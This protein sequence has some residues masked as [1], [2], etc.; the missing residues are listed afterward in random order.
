MDKLDFLLVLQ[1]KLLHLPKDDVEERLNFYN[2][3]IEDQIEEGL[4][5]EEAVSSIDSV[6][7]I[8][9]QIK[10]EI[11][12]AYLDTKLTKV[13]RKRKPVETILLIIGSPIWLSL[14][15][16]TFAVVLSL[17]ISLW[18]VVISLWSIF[19][20]LIGCAFGTVVCSIGFCIDGNIPSGLVLIAASLI[21]A[22]LCIFLF[23]VCKIVTNFAID[24]VRKVFRLRKNTIQNKEE[25]L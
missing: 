19:A 17:Y 9:E 25:A 13:K 18:A 14:L 7:E 6:D 11:D 20:S 10:T 23:F 21:C 12:S 3:M 8:A 1:E 24:L 2:E 22:G 5:E 15:I 4:S 16:A